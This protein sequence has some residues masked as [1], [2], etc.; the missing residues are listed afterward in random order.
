MRLT[1]LLAC[2]PIFAAPAFAAQL[3]VLPTK[4]H[5][6][7]PE[8]SQLLILEQTDGAFQKDLSRETQWSSSNPQVASVDANGVV[9]PI[10]DGDAVITGKAGGM[11][12]SAGVKVTN[13]HAPFVWSFRNDVMPVLSKVGCN[14]GACHG[15]LAGKSGFKLSLRG[16]D[17][18]T[19]YRTLTRQSVGRRVSLEDP[20]HSLMLLKPTFAVHHG[21]GK[22]FGTDSLQYKI[23]SEWIAEGAP[24]PKAEDVSVTGLE[25]FPAAATLHEGDEQQLVVMAKFSD[26]TE[27]D[28]TRWVKF[29]SNNAGT[30]SVDD[31]GRVGRV[32][33]VGP[34]EAAVTLWYSSRV[35]YS[36]LTVPFPNPLASNAYDQFPRHN[37]IDDLVVEKLKKLNIVPSAQCTD[38]E[39]IRR[40]Y[41]DA[42]GI[43]PRAEEVE[44]F[45][46]DT[47]ADKRSKLIDSILSRSEF[48]DYWAYKWSDLLLVS[49][50]KLNQPAMWAFYNW[51]RDGVKENKPWND[52][53]R[54]I[55]LGTGSTRENGALNYFLLHKDP[56]DLM[57]TSTE[58]FLGQ[59]ITCA[60]CHNHP[61]EKWTQNQYYEMVNL[62]SRVGIKNGSRAG[63]NVVF[64]KTSGE[65]IHPRL[66]RPMPPTPLDGKSM[67]LDSTEDR[68]RVFLEWM[69]SDKNPFFA[70]NLVNRVWANFMGRGIVNPVDDLRATNPASNEDLLAKLTEDFVKHDYDVNY[71]IRTI[72]NSATYQLSSTANA[73]NQNDNVFYSKY[74]VK[75]LPA[76]V[77]LDAYSQVSGVSTP[78]A[79]YPS[80]TRAMQLPDTQVK[81]PFLTVFGRP[82]RLVCDS[83]ERTS[84]PTVGQALSIING[85]TLNKKLSAP[86]GNI[87][88]FLKLGLSDRRILDQLFLSAYSRYP[89]DEERKRMLPAIEASRL[90][91]GTEEAK[92]E[93]HR[94]A[95]EDMTWA[96]LTSKAFLFNY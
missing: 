78:F 22:R 8:A 48:V 42:A 46:A 5:L 90:E 96:M 80:G 6:N 77:I 19:D 91:K 75:R 86:D 73:T 32:K 81:S 35:L 82:A 3:S 1:S 51:I 15:A 92:L 52:V 63:E 2:V 21:G 13:S 89:T 53:A 47:S 29:S 68:R 61:L 34:G 25:V 72:M 9:K 54:E 85:D 12:A 36:R 87:A 24:A 40:A 41:L 55:F 50:R 43:L 69:T 44:N 45:L 57:E 58:A 83:S 17:P 65:Y 16:Y 49:S 71:L 7:G 30:A 10:S 66:L 60:R 56:I 95:L 14:Q 74:I 31:D 64:A 4:V 26:G 27:R 88:L 76:E 18:E 70:R 93:A 84:D 20:A 67:S 62:F 79:G 33:M 59:R 38:A 39:F 28:V 37:Y 94:Q 11:E 23:I